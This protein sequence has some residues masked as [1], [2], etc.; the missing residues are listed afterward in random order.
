MSTLTELIGRRKQAETA[1][2]AAIA[3]GISAPVAGA[4]GT[5]AGK[6]TASSSYVRSLLLKKE[7]QE[8]ILTP[9]SLSPNDQA[10]VGN[11]A[12][13]AKQSE[14]GFFDGIPVVNTIGKFGKELGEFGLNLPGGLYNLGKSVTH[15]VLHNIEHPTDLS[16][17]LSNPFSST[18]SE[19]VKNVIAP[20]A[21]YY[22]EKY[23][24][25]S[26]GE[27][28]SRA[29][30]EPFATT[31]DVGSVATLGAGSAGRIGG[32]LSKVGEAGQAADDSSILGR[33]A[34][35]A[36]KA[37]NYLGKF[38]YQ[39]TRGTRPALE[40]SSGELYPREYGTSP[41]I[42]LGQK[43]SDAYLGKIPGIG[44]K[45]SH[46]R[47]QIA[48][49]GFINTAAG[50][51]RVLSA[52][53]QANESEPVVKAIKSLSEDEEL[54]LSL[55]K[56]GVNDQ[57]ARMGAGMKPISMIDSWKEYIQHSLE[58][59]LP[60]GYNAWNMKGLGEKGV[61]K[62]YI[63]SL[64]AKLDE[65][66]FRQLMSDPSHEMIDAS[67]VWDEQVQKSLDTMPIDLDE[68]NARTFQL[69]EA[70]RTNPGK[71]KDTLDEAGNAQSI[72]AVKDPG[73]AFERFSAKHQ[74]E[75]G[76]SFPIEPNY[77]PHEIAEGTFKGDL[78]KVKRSDPVQ[79]VLS[80]EN[81][82]SLHSAKFLKDNDLK[83]AL[84][85]ALQVGMR[86]AL[87]HVLQREFIQVYNSQVMKLLDRLGAKDREGELIKVRGWTEAELKGYK[88]SGYELFNPEGDTQLIKAE[89]D[90]M[91]TIAETVGELQRDHP[92]QVK[93]RIGKVVESL[94]S[95][96]ESSAKKAASDQE[97][98]SLKTPHYILTRDAA[99][100]LEK[101]MSA[102]KP[103]QHLA[104]RGYDNLMQ[105]WRSATLGFMPRWWINTFAGNIFM[106]ALSGGLRPR[107][108]GAAWRLGKSDMTDRI[109]RS[110]ADADEIRGQRAVRD[111]INNSLM[112]QVP[113]HAPGNVGAERAETRA[114]VDVT[115]RHPV[116]RVSDTIF[117]KVE[118]IDTYFR[119]A[120]LLQEMDKYAKAHMHQ[121]GEVMDG[122]SRWRLGDEYVKNI[123]DN[124]PDLV[125]KAMGEANKFF[126]N[127]TA[128]GPTERRLVRRIIPFYGWYKFITKLAWSLPFQYPGRTNLLA[129]LTNISK[130][131]TENEFGILPPGMKGSILLNNDLTNTKYLPTFG[132]NP[133]ADF[134]NPSSPEGTI[135]GLLSTSQLAPL[136]KSG[137]SAIGV[138]PFGGSDEFDPTGNFLEGNYGKVFNAQGEEVPG[139]IQGVN[140][141]QRFTG[142]LVGSIPEVNTLATIMNKGR[143]EYPEGIPLIAPKP[144]LWQEP[145]S[146]YDSSGGEAQFILRSFLGAVPKY[147]NLHEYQEGLKEEVED[148]KKHKQS[149]IKSFRK[150]G[151]LP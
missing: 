7:L 31:L 42:R 61:D 32:I 58:D 27:I 9:Q 24:T 115:K 40:V 116:K 88:K 28:L 16:A 69:Q 143:G 45:L 80:A 34:E 55:L 60:M 48:Q 136:V 47:G 85:G 91:K 97:A 87:K 106:S 19:T 59:K 131:Y 81:A 78:L 139:G 135:P 92:D 12:I 11:Q 38:G 113:E 149:Q 75:T 10:L 65:P 124:H 101:S 111:E 20:T 148:A 128:L 105:M 145:R 36:S 99:K 142:S 94:K 26:P 66:G 68:H 132:L 93:G 123:V 137:L 13:K 77:I 104:L 30:N 1:R 22:K 23:L 54:A 89:N 122:Y 127:F 109:L 96:I 57:F 119:K 138:S 146:S 83:A 4:F 44:Q 98:I 2:N 50:R 18:N 3:T 150:A 82:A 129:N 134:A 63:K 102:L 112:E 39:G 74:A 62:G 86:P 110:T 107:Y 140:S 73:A 108:L 52:I 41:L 144:L 6:S 29:V 95:E 147:E 90:Q 17:D 37:G 125:E 120:G 5:A 133:F 56:N 100:N 70:L 35:P 21:Q 151:T 25:G 114:M 130:E 49:K 51:V 76:G 15:D 141:L 46:W 72:E 14:G 117:N 79:R 103:E 8:G 126:Y 84:S 43:A 71:L 53:H 33:V 67:D 118:K 121:L 64:M